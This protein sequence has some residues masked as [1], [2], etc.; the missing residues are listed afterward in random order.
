[1]KYLEEYFNKLE[2]MGSE[3]LASEIS[4][5]MLDLTRHYL[6]LAKKNNS[7]D[8]FEVQKLLDEATKCYT[9]SYEVLAVGRS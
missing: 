7:S 5:A 6:F 8:I 2:S 1:V 3:D 9:K 4:E